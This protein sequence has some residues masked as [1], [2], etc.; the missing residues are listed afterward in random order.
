[1]HL[2]LHFLAG[3]RCFCEWIFRNFSFFRCSPTDSFTTTALLSVI[4]ID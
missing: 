2:T 1:V 3:T 4:L